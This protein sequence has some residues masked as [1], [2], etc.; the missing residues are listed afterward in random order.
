MGRVNCVV[1]SRRSK[2]GMK[3]NGDNA[4]WCQSTRG[5][6][7]TTTNGWEGDQ[8]T[9]FSPVPGAGGTRQY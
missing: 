2:E 6:V 1:D 3:W 7:G 5:E 4:W 9:S 8:K